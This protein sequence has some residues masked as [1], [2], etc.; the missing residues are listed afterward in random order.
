MNHY[1][2]EA[3]DQRLAED[4]VFCPHGLKLLKIRRNAGRS[5]DFQ[6]TQKDVPV[7]YCELKSPRDEWL[8]RKLD[9]APPGKLV[10]GYRIDSTFNRIARQTQKAADQFRA[11][12][13]LRSMPNILVFVNHDDASGFSDLIETFSG[14]FYASDGSRHVTMPQVASRLKHAKQHVDLCVWIDRSTSQIYHYFNLASAPNYLH[15]LCDLMSINSA[16]IKT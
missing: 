16:D 15:F 12:N 4:L 2:T 13:T 7:A 11:V 8:D 6:V 9:E 5:P 10:C 14:M 1:P 3:D